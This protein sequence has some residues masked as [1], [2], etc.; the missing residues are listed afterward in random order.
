MYNPVKNNRIGNKKV[1]NP[2]PSKTKKSLRF[3]PNFPKRLFA[4][5]DLSEKLLRML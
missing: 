5:N 4:A 1:A 3:A 2:K